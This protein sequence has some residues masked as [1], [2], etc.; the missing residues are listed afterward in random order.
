MSNGFKNIIKQKEVFS[1]SVRSYELE[2]RITQFYA[3]RG[4]GGGRFVD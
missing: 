4:N 3:P 1:V 2:R